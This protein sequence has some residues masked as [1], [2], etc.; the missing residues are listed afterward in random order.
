M[1]RH[2][3]VIIGSFLL[4]PV[5]AGIAL[6]DLAGIFSFTDFPFLLALL[7][8]FLFIFIQKST[9]RVTFI[10]ALYFLILMGLS[11]IPTSTSLITERLGEWFYLFFFISI[12]QYLMEVR[13]IR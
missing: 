2:K 7:L 12:I 6:L 3:L 4:I 1:L 13:R 10:V 9:S 8:L 5:I 11:Y